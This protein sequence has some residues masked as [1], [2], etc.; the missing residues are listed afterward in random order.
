MKNP[1]KFPLRSRS[2]ITQYLAKH[3]HYH[4]M[5]SW[6]RGFVISWNVKIYYEDRTGKSGSETINPFYD[7]KW[8]E[9]LEKRGNNLFWRACE[10]TAY[11]LVNGEYSTYH[12]YDQDSYQF[13]FNGSQ[14][15]HIWLS[16]CYIVPQPRSWAM[17]PF[18]FSDKEAWQDYLNELSF[19][20]LRT[21]YRAIATMDQDFTRE[22]I[23]AQINENFNRYRFDWELEQEDDQ[24]KIAAIWEG[25]RPDMYVY[26]QHS[27]N[28]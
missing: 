25:L 8:Q 3:A 2:A 21:L 4:P 18:I 1:Y 23:T 24:Y 14:G 9:Y 5:R 27:F 10:D 28:I 19:A 17:A 26:S 7:E 12:G 15:G 20:N 22:K 13:C 11:C 16:H 6:N